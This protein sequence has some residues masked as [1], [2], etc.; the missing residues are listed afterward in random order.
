MGKIKIIGT[1][2]LNLPVFDETVVKVDSWY[3]RHTKDYCIQL[4]NKDDYQVGDSIRVGTKKDKDSEVERLK[5]EY[6]L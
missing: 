1:G 6:N 2:N 4:K 5:R 3:D